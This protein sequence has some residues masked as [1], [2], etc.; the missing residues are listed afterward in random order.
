[1]SWKE[2]HETNFRSAETK[3]NNSDPKG[4]RETQTRWKLG[5][6]I[7]TAEKVENKIDDG[8]KYQN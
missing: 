8:R 2:L 1:M 4:I 5:A 6:E 7:R 3:R